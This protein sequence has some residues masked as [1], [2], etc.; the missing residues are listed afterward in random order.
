[1][2]MFRRHSKYSSLTK[3]V[4]EKRVPET[5][6]LHEAELLRLDNKLFLVSLP[7]H[8]SSPILSQEYVDGYYVFKTRSSVYKT[9]EFPVQHDITCFTKLKTSNRPNKA[10]REKIM[11]RFEYEDHLYSPNGLDCDCF[12][13]FWSNSDDVVCLLLVCDAANGLTFA[14]SMNRPTR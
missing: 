1:M 10:C 7:E 3:H 13:R 5:Y 8:V 2:N 12:G 11:L 14:I 4:P 9:D 6:L